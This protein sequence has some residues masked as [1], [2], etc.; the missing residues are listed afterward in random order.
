M[1]TDRRP[2]GAAEVRDALL[3]SAERLFA[4]EDPG[5]VSLR[6]IAADADVNYGLVHRHLG[7]KLDVVEATVRRRSNAYVPS[8]AA[9]DD[10]IERLTE[11]V[12]HYLQGP[13]VARTL[14]WAAMTGADPHRL[15]D[16][17]PDVTELVEMLKE[18]SGDTASAQMFV[19]FTAAAVLGL[20]VFGEIAMVAAGAPED[21]LD[22]LKERAAEWL[23]DLA[24]RLGLEP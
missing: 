14:A 21:D 17:L 23:G 1:S 11:M 3:A 16:G 12:N 15:V 19:A 6:R 13:A 7:S 4:E 18:R 8:D 24:A 20:G 22:E 9:A 10:P 2:Q 5:T